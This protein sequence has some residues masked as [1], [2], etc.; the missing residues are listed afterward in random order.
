MSG[1]K[2]PILP[3]T[4]FFASLLLEAALHFGF[5]IIGIIAYPW[6]LAGLLPVVV[7]IAVSALGSK[8]FERR[9]TTIKPFQESSALVVDGIFRYSRNPMY[10]AMVVILGGVAVILGSLSPWIV[11]TVF[12]FVMTRR[13]ILAEEAMLME[14]FGEQYAA[15]QRAVRRWI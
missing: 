8:S 2:Q 9:G 11:V 5:P 3:P 4:Y 12:P 7:G 1:Q 13:F 10:L 6:R 15:Y 14:T